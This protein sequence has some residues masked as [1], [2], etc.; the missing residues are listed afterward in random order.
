M[1]RLFE[2]PRNW[3]ECLAALVN[4]LDSPD[5]DKQEVCGKASSVILC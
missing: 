5:L 2:E 1:I 4:L 3:P